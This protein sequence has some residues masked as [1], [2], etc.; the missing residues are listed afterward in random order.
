MQV[1]IHSIRPPSKETGV[2]QQMC[3][4]TVHRESVPPSKETRCAPPSKI[5]TNWTVATVQ[6]ET[7]HRPKILRISGAMICGIR[8]R[9]EM[10]KIS[11]ERFFPGL[12]RVKI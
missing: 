10:V 9:S 5:E 7:L 11:K 8:R 12:S 4:A 2:N 6:R 1:L 3:E